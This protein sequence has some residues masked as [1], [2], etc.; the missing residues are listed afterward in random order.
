V[1]ENGKVQPLHNWRNNEPANGYL[2]RNGKHWFLFS[3]CEGAVLV[4]SGDKGAPSIK[5]GRAYPAHQYNRE[6]GVANLLLPPCLGFG[7]PEAIAVGR[8]GQLAVLRLPSGSTPATSDDPALLLAP[9]SEPIAL[10]PW[11]TLELASSPACSSSTEGSR[12]LIQTPVSWLAGESLAGKAMTAIVRWSTARVCLEAVEAPHASA[13]TENWLVAR[14]VGKS[15]GASLITRKG[16]E[17][18]RQ[19]V[20]CSVAPASAASLEALH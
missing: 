5:L 15:P 12:A 10:A 8:Q 20:T 16:D 18:Y 14:F 19:A 1:T 13:T 2:D 17:T 9:G 3:N 6:R 11:S 7:N 4:T